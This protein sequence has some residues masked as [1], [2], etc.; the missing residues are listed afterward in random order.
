MIRQNQKIQISWGLCVLALLLVSCSNEQLPEAVEGDLRH[1]FVEGLNGPE[2]VDSAFRSNPAQ[3]NDGDEFGLDPSNQ[4]N[5]AVLKM[6][7]SAVEYL[8]DQNQQFPAHPEKLEL[9]ILEEQETDNALEPVAPDT[10]KL[11]HSGQNEPDISEDREALGLNDRT[12]GKVIRLVADSITLTDCVMRGEIRNLSDDQYARNVTITIGSLEGVESVQWHWPLTMKPGENAPFELQIDWFPHIYNFDNPIGDMQHAL[13]IDNWNWFAN[14]YL[15]AEAEMSLVPDLKRAFELNSDDTEV[16]VLWQNPG[17]RFLIYDERALELESSQQWYRYGREQSVISVPSFASALPGDFVKSKD[18]DPMLSEFTLYK[19]SDLFYVPSRV[20]PNIYREAID[21]TVTYVKVYQAHKR[22]SGVIDVWEL[23][24]HSVSEEVDAQDVLLDRQLDPK[25]DF[26]NYDVSP[27]EF[28]YVQLLRLPFDLP[29]QFP[30]RNVAGQDSTHREP[31]VGYATSYDLWVGG[32]SHNEVSSSG[33]SLMT[34]GDENSASCYRLGPLCVGDFI[35]QGQMAIQHTNVLGRFGSCPNLESDA[36]PGNIIYVDRDSITLSDQ[37]I[38]GLMYNSSQ[39]EVARDVTV[40]ASLENS[41]IQIG[42][43]RWPLSM[44]PREPAPFEILHN[45]PDLKTEDLQFRVSAKLSEDADPTRSFLLETYTGG[46][47]YGTDYK[48]LYEDMPFASP[49]P[50]YYEIRPGQI[51]DHNAITL[52]P[53]NRYTKSEFLKLYGDSVWLEEIE[54]ME[55]FSFS[56][57]YARL[58]PPDSHPELA[59]ISTSQY[60]HDLRAFTAIVAGDGRVVDVKEVTL[61][62]PVYGQANISEPFVEVDS[63]PA[64]NGWS[65]NA[66]RLMRIIPYEDEADMEEGYYSQVWIGGATEPVE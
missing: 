28:A 6:S 26:V 48:H 22:G 64:P 24:P 4:A 53:R 3:S 15:D 27:D 49:Y 23:I 36:R 18:F 21:D 2:S 19:Y 10:S 50:M 31:S 56:D 14:T 11:Y 8:E 13:N 44:Q 54:E 47:V 35:L 65:P 41:E 25:V 55:L 29:E 43:W 63:I 40:F 61:F 37:E 30:A 57:I 34:L 52:L 39:T 1:I 32:V 7:D 45:V 20:Y 59:K 16:E 12:Q 33:D 5:V 17:H 38:R 66:V 58:V 62:T 46:T 42:T 60:I 9:G 51:F